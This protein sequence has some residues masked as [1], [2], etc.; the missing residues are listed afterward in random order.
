MN[1]RNFILAIS[2]GIFLFSQLAFAASEG[3]SN[4]VRTMANIMN[5]LNHY[6]ADPEKRKLDKIIKDANSKNYEK[7]IAKAMMGMQHKVSS[8]DKAALSK[9][10]SDGSV[11]QGA[12]DLA[13]VL[14]NLNHKPSAADKA[15]LKKYMW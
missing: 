10:A 14:Q 8:S 15:I 13:K 7:T 3:P 4:S 12:R 5:Y 2:F 11:P 6:P 9:I 1:K